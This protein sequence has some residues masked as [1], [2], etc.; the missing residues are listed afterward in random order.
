MQ[1]P[2]PIGVVPKAVMGILAFI[3]ILIFTT[4]VEGTHHGARQWYVESQTGSETRDKPKSIWTEPSQ[5]GF[6]LYYGDLGMV[7]V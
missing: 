7:Q 3:I 1:N 2:E 5:G 6:L 4:W